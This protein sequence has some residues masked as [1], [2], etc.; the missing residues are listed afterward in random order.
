[1]GSIILV[2]LDDVCISNANRQLHATTSSIGKM[3]I[4]VMRDRL[5]D[6]NPCCDVVLV[7]DFVT[8]ENAYD[9]M[10]SMMSSSSSF[11]S[12]FSSTS[13]SSS[14][15]SSGDG[16]GEGS[17]RRGGLTA[18]IDAIDGVREKTALL[19]AC[20]AWGIPVVTCGGAAGRMDPTK[21]IVDDLTKV[22]ED[23]L[24]FKCRKSMRQDFGFAK[25]PPSKKKGGQQRVRSWRIHAVHSTE[26]I[27][28]RRRTVEEGGEDE[29]EDYSPSS[30]FRACDGAGVGTAS[31]VTGTYGLAAA[32]KVVEMIALDELVVPK[33]QGNARRG[34]DEDPALN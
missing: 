29:D 6:I 5:M 16:G 8:S 11:S 13:S 34:I 30:S 27:R 9:L 31:F 15:S 4:D 20:V 2:D 26:V 18:C 22:S 19:L 33:R 21:V 12:S 28:K 23:R 14:S 3:K 10:G 7:H 25:V 17:R 1:V 24:L 32:C